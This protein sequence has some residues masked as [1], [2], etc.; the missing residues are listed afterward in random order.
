MN[1][2]Q[3]V[4]IFEAKTHFSQLCDQVSLTRQPL[5]VQRRGKALVMISPVETRQEQEGEDIFSAWQRWN[6]GHPEDQTDF[7]DVTALRIT[8]P[9]KSFE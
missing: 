3:T 9:A 2:A 5:L 6:A 1:T 7:P 4:G 8:K